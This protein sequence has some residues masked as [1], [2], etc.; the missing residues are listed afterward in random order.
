MAPRG[1]G[2]P[3]RDVPGFDPEGPIDL[4]A[5]LPANTPRELEIGFGRARFLLD[6]AAL[7]PDVQLLGIET[8][9]KWVHRAAER[10]TR[11]RLKNVVVRHGDARA[12]LA[13]MAPD[14]A[15]VR[16]FVN[17]PDP[18]WKARHEK[19]LV[20][21]T[22]LLE[23]I[24]RLLADDGELF[25]ETDVDY[26]FEAY[27]DAVNAV[28]ELVGK[29]GDPVVEENPFGVRSSREHRCVEL[30]LPVFRLLARRRAR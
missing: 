5:L 6:R 23:Q 1:S 21:T 19:R 18:W 3:Y 10:A 4:T 11:R 28:P 9:R 30:G 16:V 15:L 14:A 2:N 29:G 7:V 12:A 22:D 13:R 8:R 25:I 17:F 20:V 26:R 27:L 24:V